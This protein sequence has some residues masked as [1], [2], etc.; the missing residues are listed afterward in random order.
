[1][2][3]SPRNDPIRSSN[4]VPIVIIDN[5]SRESYLLATLEHSGWNKYT[6]HSE[7]RHDLRS[8]LHCLEL[9]PS[10]DK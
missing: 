6:S 5:G 8:L 10:V 1:M 2:A 7:L 4:Q 9:C 3:L